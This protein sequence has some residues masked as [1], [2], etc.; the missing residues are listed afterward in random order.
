L[1]KRI[2]ALRESEEKYR[3]LVEEISDVIYRIDAGG[4][5]TY[6]NPAIESIIE[7]TPEQLVGKP[8]AHYIHPEDLG[9]L[10]K[11]FQN[12]LSGET[13]GPAEYRVQ[14]NSGE[15]R[16]IRVTSQPIDDGDGI[17]GLQGVLTDITERKKVELQLEQAAATA[18]RDRLARRLHDAVTQTLFS[19]SIIAESTPR[20]MENDPDLAKRNLEQL[21]TM[22]R[23]SLA[24][25][26]TML[27]EL[28]PEALIGK[29]IGELI[30]TLSE[31][32]QTRINCPVHIVIDDERDPPEDVTIVFYRIAQEA[33]SNIIKYAEAS[34]VSINLACD[35]DAVVMILKDN[36]RGFEPD[37]V[38][39]GHIGLNIMAERIEQIG[40]E[41]TIDSKPGQGTQ[42]TAKW[43]ELSEDKNH[44]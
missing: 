10:Q 4:V 43:S 23:G 8:M 42:I 28:R 40:G 14:T 41:L 36:G 6:L 13:A 1:D 29:Q 18:E 32:S 38:P 16:W 26:R 2:I 7:L 12:L 21:S 11:N 20:I 33:F 31:A 15:T 37:Q 34:E 19:A 39:P 17:I 24:E 27:I 5:I 44:A 25:M 30:Q 3:D 9:Q 22:L 35:K